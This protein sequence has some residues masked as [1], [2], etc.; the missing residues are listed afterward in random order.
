MVK[1]ATFWHRHEARD[2][3]TKK[4]PDKSRPTSQEARI[5]KKWGEKTAQTE[6]IIFM[7]SAP[8]QPKNVP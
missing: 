2:V 7:M 8:A 1:S 6:A 5:R 3:K 4:Y